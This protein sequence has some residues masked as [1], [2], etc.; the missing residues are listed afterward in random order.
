MG[1]RN[2]PIEAQVHRWPHAFPQFEVGHL[3]RIGAITAN[4]P[5]GVALAGAAMRGVGI[6][7]CIAGGRAAA[8]GLL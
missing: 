8:A 5:R 6:A 1:L 4:L 7:T 2:D 3:D